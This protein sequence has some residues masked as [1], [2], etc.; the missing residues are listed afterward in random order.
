M[1]ERERLTKKWF[2][3]WLKANCE[4][5]EEI[6][7]SDAVYIESWGPKYSGINEICRWFKEWNTRGKVVAWDIKQFFHKDEQTVAEWYF[8][9]KFESGGGDCFDG[10]SLIRW[11][12]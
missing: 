8:C 1:E 7:T 4:G 2:D 12:N 9:S 11:E 6:F 10:M 3:M 5:V